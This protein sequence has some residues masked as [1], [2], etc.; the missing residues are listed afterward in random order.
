MAS[1]PLADLDA[2]DAE[3]ADASFA[4]MRGFGKRASVRL[5]R[6]HRYCCSPR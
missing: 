2:R 5:C 1:L 3:T 4:I 6:L